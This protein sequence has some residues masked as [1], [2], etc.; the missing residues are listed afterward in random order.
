[1]GQ[2]ALASGFGKML[3]G[4]TRETLP[5]GQHSRRY[6]PVRIQYNTYCSLIRLPG[7]NTMLKHPR[8][9]SHQIFTLIS[10]RNLLFNI[11][12]WGGCPTY[13]APQPPYL[14][15]KY[16]KG[17]VQQKLSANRWVLAWDCGAGHYYEVSIRCR[18]VLN[19]FPFPVSTA[20]L[21]GDFYNNRQSAANS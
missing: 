3:P 16:I 19:I 5:R 10:L 20:K 9:L 17:S 21:L 14:P 6:I 11:F 13:P 7:P 18:L 8:L 12:V 4:E 2:K 15:A 1:M